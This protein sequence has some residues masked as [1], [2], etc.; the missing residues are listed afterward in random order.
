MWASNQT[1]NLYT[2]KG[3]E[4]TAGPDYGKPKYQWAGLPIIDGKADPHP[5]R[6]TVF[7]R[8]QIQLGARYTF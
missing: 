6:T 5:S 3:L 2:F 8:Y 7:S 4:K 1:V